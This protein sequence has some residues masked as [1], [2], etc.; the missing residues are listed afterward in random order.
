MFEISMTDVCLSVSSCISLSA[1]VCVT[2]SVTCQ[3]STVCMCV[4][5]P[6]MP[7]LA[8]VV[9]G[10]IIH[11]HWMCIDTLQPFTLISGIYCCTC[12]G[13]CGVVGNKRERAGGVCTG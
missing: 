6:T 10:L 1:C 13:M 4:F 3:C 12:H 11:R 5:E 2:V 7:I 8:K 9:Y